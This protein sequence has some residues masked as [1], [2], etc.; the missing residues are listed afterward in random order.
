LT[1]GDE[2]HLGDVVASYGTDADMDGS[3]P[4]VVAK[5]ALAR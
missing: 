5:L 3:A 2:E 4:V 1:L